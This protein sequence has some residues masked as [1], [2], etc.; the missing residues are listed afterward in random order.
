MF[1][2]VFREMLLA[3][4][5]RQ[6]ERDTRWSY[7]RK[8]RRSAAPAAA[9]APVSLRLCTVHDDPA[10]TRLAALDGRPVPIGCL[11]VAEIGG[12]IVAAQALDGGVPLADPFYPTAH[13]LPL[14]RL[15]ALQIETGANRRSFLA[16][17]WS[18]VRGF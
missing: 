17:G 11:V 14:L 7:A 10:L 4:H 3:E 8:E 1:H 18:A 6:V 5:A 2:P 16:R 12:K 15:R 9:E 13:V